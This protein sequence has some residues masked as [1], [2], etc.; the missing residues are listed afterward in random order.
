MIIY[1]IV[2]MTTS[3]L[4]FAVIYTFYSLKLTKPLSIIKYKNILFT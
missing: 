1:H 3:Y 4:R 2:N